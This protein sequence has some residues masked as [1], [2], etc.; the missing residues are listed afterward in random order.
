MGKNRI[1]ERRKLECAKKRKDAEKIRQK[2][3]EVEA[4]QKRDVEQED[5]ENRKE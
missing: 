5:N 1:G 2:K 4:G 3:V